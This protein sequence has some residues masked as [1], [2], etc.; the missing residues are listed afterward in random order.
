[1]NIITGNNVALEKIVFWSFKFKTRLCKAK[2]HMLQ[3]CKVIRDILGECNY[4]I[5]VPNASFSQKICNNLINISFGERK[6]ASEKTTSKRKN[7]QCSDSV[8]KA[9]H[10]YQGK[11]ELTTKNLSQKSP[12]RCWALQDF[13][14]SW[15]K[16]RDTCLDISLFKEFKS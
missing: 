9:V 4:G 14:R 2:E 16:Q 15:P 5:S 10:R 3:L 11:A 7:W 13:H 6:E 8:E 1:M 12:L